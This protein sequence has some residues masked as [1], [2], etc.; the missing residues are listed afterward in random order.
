M[1]CSPDF[2]FWGYGMAEMWRRLLVL[3][4]VAAGLAV[5][6][7]AAADELAIKATLAYPP[8]YVL[9]E[10]VDVIV[11][12]W[13]SNDYYEKD[14]ARKVTHAGAGKLRAS[15]VVDA[16]RLDGPE[17]YGLV[18]TVQKE[19]KVLL[20][21]TPFWTG[22]DWVDSVN[23]TRK[24]F[25]NGLTVQLVEFLEYEEL[26]QEQRDEADAGYMAIM[27]TWDG[28]STMGGEC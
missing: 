25:R 3:L 6:G 11:Q 8:D 28:Q 7:K 26:N 1:V 15:L 19:G 12:F 22:N 2:A 18:V 10:V 5:G 27:C 23:V 13:G 14:I 4:I 20:A 21:S 9:P 24:S 16:D 17:I